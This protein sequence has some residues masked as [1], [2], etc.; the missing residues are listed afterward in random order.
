MSGRTEGGAK[1]RR[2]HNS[3][4]LYNHR[5]DRRDRRQ[6]LGDAGPTV[7]FVIGCEECT[8]GRAEID[9][10]RLHA[11]GRHRLA[12][13]A[14]EGVLLREAFAHVLPGLAAVARTPHGRL[15]VGHEAAMDVAIERQQI[16]R[17]R[18]AR[19]NCRWEAEAGGKARL[20]AFPRLA[21][22]AAAIHAAMV[23]RVEQVRLA[24]R[25]DQ[26]M[27]ALAEFRIVLPL[28]HEVRT[29]ALVAPLPRLAAIAREEHA[30]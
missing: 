15:G 27:H 3:L 30:G 25:L 20:Y 14:E 1:D 16:E 2:H 8:A 22:I 24:G 13:Y 21:G 10:R 7:A 5:F 4:P 11:V 29:G 17:R 9:T 23:L 19:V 18:I 6:V 12:Q 26:A 28:R